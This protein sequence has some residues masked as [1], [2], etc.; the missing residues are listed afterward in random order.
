MSNSSRS[1][2]IRWGKVSGPVTSTIGI[3]PRASLARF[4]SPST[5]TGGHLVF[6]QVGGVGDHDQGPECFL[7]P[8]PDRAPVVAA[9]VPGED[10][11]LAGRQNRAGAGVA[12]QFPLQGVQLG[13]GRAD[14]QA[15]PQYR[16]RPSRRRCRPAGSASRTA[17]S[18]KSRSVSSLPTVSGPSHSAALVSTQLPVF[19]NLFCC[20]RLG[21]FQWRRL[22]C[23][24]QRHH[25]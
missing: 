13:R 20:K 9:Q 7:G 5:S 1:R 12:E 21:S 2:S 14:E 15:D 24:F 23:Q 3:S 25:G 4:R 17:G 10:D 16:A 19:C 6:A 22:P 8:E 18:A 11:P